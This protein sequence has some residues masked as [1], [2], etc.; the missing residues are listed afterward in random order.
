M[1]TEGPK[2]DFLSIG[3]VSCSIRGV[4]H[5]LRSLILS[6]ALGSVH[7]STLAHGP[8]E[9]RP[10]A[11]SQ[12]T[13]EQRIG[14]EDTPYRL[15][16]G[17]SFAPTAGGDDGYEIMGPENEVIVLTHPS[18]TSEYHVYPGV[19]YRTDNSVNNG[20]SYCPCRTWSGLTKG[21]KE[22]DSKTLA[23]QEDMLDRMWQ[24]WEKEGIRFGGDNP[25]EFYQT[26]EPEDPV[27]RLELWKN[28]IKGFTIP[29][30]Q[31]SNLV[32][33]EGWKLDVR[34][35]TKTPMSQKGHEGLVDGYEVDAS[36]RAK[37]L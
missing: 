20:I 11:E 4:R 30:I 24:D 27:K 22:R 16:D 37:E 28:H 34:T 12:L 29:A 13:L 15:P 19:E 5:T 32:A 36:W 23:S 17:Y 3:S 10:F 9:T 21:S 8:G 2:S 18:G 7:S 33:N 26:H 6:P 1:Q 14:T 35:G 31:R 25:S